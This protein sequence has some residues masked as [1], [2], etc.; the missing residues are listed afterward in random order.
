MMNKSNKH[1]ED[2]KR[3]KK[4][5]IIKGLSKLTFDSPFII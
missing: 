4:E 3:S 2:N 5:L 1:F